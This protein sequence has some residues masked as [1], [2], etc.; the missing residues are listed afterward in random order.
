VVYSF[1]KLGIPVIMREWQ[2]M[3]DKKL[4]K[5]QTMK[6]CEWKTLSRK[7]PHGIMNE[8]IGTEHS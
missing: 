4:M 1:P 7:M 2:Q 6:N 3:R 5:K 8:N